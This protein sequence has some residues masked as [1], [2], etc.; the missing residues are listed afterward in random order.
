MT[1]NLIAIIQAIQAQSTN[2]IDLIQ[3][4]D[5][6]YNN[7]WNKLII[8][9]S[10]ALGI[11]GLIVPLFIQLYQRRTLKLSEKLLMQE[12]GSQNIKTKNETIV[13][14]SKKIEEKFGEYENKIK[15]M[16][17]SANAK[18]YLTQGKLELE[19]NYYSPALSY[20]VACAYS[21][22]ECNDHQNL[23]V[24]LKSILNECLPH[25]SVEEINDIKVSKESDIDYFLSHLKEKDDIGYYSSIIQDI[26]LKI[27]KLPKTVK[28]KPQEQPKGQT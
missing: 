26:K 1:D 11:V 2:V 21:C 20:F 13:E 7:A 3:K 22:I 23:Q 16:S 12:L 9:G 17:A 19:K 5:A 25:L 4:I 28:E 8:I 27:T 18:I 14:L 15:I 24:A 6:F 10:V